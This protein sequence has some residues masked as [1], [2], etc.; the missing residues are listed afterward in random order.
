[1]LKKSVFFLPLLALGITA[2]DADGDGI[3]NKDELELGTDPDLADSD[4]DGVDDGDEI[5]QSTDPNNADSDGDGLNDGEELA[6]GTDPNSEDSDGDGYLDAW[7][8]NEGSDPANGDSLIYTGHWPYNPSKDADAPDTDGAIKAIGELMARFTAVDQFGDEV[9][10]YDF[11]M[12]GKPIL[13]DFSTEW[14]PPC[15]GMASWL[16]GKGDSS[17]F[18]SVYPNIK[19]HVDNGDIRWITVLAQDGSRNDAKGDTVTRWDES[20]PHEEIPV[21]AHPASGYKYGSGWPSVFALNEDM[22]IAALPTGSNHWNAMDW[23]NNYSP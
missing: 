23:A 13:I 4:G 12:E 14:C 6:L 9:D 2:C 19:T 17:G 1:M 16:A 7:E 11:A 8:V 5:D 10:L 15:N 3:S 21:L 20:Y 18:G 22:T